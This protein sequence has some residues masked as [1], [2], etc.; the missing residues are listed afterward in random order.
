MTSCEVLFE[1]LYTG[2]CARM[3]SHFS[4]VRLFAILWTV[5]HQASL[6]MSF[7]RHEHWSGLVSPP[8]DLPDPR[9]KP[10]SLM[11]CLLL[12][13]VGSLP[14]APPGK[15]LSRNNSPEIRRK[16]YSDQLAID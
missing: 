3:L 14:L 6:S 7:S 16:G 4:H 10:V 2:M 11:S 1:R 8:G 13:Q 12:W 5:P 15:P 9:T